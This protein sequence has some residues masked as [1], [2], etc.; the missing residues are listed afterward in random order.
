MQNENTSNDFSAS[1]KYLAAQGLVVTIKQDFNTKNAIGS[2]GV[3]KAT[4]SGVNKGKFP[5]LTKL[6]N[7]PAGEKKQL[8]SKWKKPISNSRLRKMRKHN[9]TLQASV[10]RERSRSNSDSSRSNVNVKTKPFPTV[11]NNKPTYRIKNVDVDLERSPNSLI[12]EQKILLQGQIG[13]S[14]KQI[15]DF[16][17]GFFALCAVGCTPD[18]RLGWLMTFNWYK[19]ILESGNESLIDIIDTYFVKLQRN[20]QDPINDSSDST[21]SN[22]PFY[23]IK[24]PNPNNSPIVLT[25]SESSDDEL[26]IHYD[27]DKIIASRDLTN[28]NTTWLEN[29]DDWIANFCTLS[30]TKIT[31][32]IDD[33]RTD[34]QNTNTLLHDDMKLV[35]VTYTREPRL[36]LFDQSFRIP[37][38]SEF[39]H[40]RKR[41]V[42]SLEAASQILTHNNVNAL[43]ADSVIDYK[44]SSA[45]A[46]VST[47]NFDRYK[48]LEFEPT[49]L[50]QNTFNLCHDLANKLKYENRYRDFRLG[51]NSNVLQ[52]TVT[53][54]M[55]YFF[56]RS[57]KLRIILKSAGL[58]LIA[59]VWYVNFPAF[60]WAV[61]SW[62][63]LTLMPIPILQVPFWTVVSTA[64]VV[65]PLPLYV[66]DSMSFAN[67]FAFGCATTL[68]HFYR[69]LIWPLTRG[70]MHALAS[71]P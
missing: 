13:L 66:L 57:Q 40:I 54:P 58:I 68:Y 3:T 63:R 35:D 18:Q 37:Y 71:L 43:L 52:S 6:L 61:N 12:H 51:P 34:N 15:G 47:V 59:M 26:E 49:F 20:V 10:E 9:E 70:W 60:R 24:P 4:A 1:L 41:T 7:E 28:V 56:P 44:L 2:Q 25:S 38:I 42:A 32:D 62:V 11:N 14:D 21:K 27:P 31:Y 65:N 69:L 50:Q 48:S 16:W 53:E 39:F 8:Q 45:I 46:A 33:L 64:L 19:S 36:S 17:P 23:G 67:L 30:T 5:T 22:S 55:K 29:W